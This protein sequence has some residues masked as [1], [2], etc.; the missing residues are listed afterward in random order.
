MFRRIVKQF[1]QF[2]EH[3]I[4]KLEKVKNKV[5][6]AYSE[7]YIEADFLD[8]VKKRRKLNKE[9]FIKE[10]TELEIIYRFEPFERALKKAKK[11]FEDAKRNGD[12]DELYKLKK[13]D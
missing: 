2:I 6:N 13:E 7:T 5:K 4:P 11:M 3:I 12:L 1:V 9:H 10:I 8:E